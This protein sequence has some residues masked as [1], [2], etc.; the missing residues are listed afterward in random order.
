M[1]AGYA[2]R[3]KDYPNKG[4]CGLPELK[5]TPRQLKLK[6]E[7]L[8]KLVRDAAGIAE[9]SR[10]GDDSDSDDDSDDDDSDEEGSDGNEKKG[11]GKKKGKKGKQV[12]NNIIKPRGRIVVLTGAGISTSSGIPDFRGPRGIWTMEKN[13]KKTQKSN[14]QKNKKRRRGGGN[15]DDCDG[16]GD[17]VDKDEGGSS[18]NGGSSGSGSSGSKM[19]A[20]PKKKK[21]TTNGES[22]GDGN[23][24]TKDNGHGS[25]G[26]GAAAV[27]VAK[28][29]FAKAAPTYT[30]R[31]VTELVSRRRVVSYVVTQNVDGLHR[32]SGLSRNDHAVLH[33]CVFTEKCEKCGAEYFHD[34]DVGGMSFQPTGRRCTLPALGNDD[35]TGNGNGDGNGKKGCNG[36]LR[37]TLLDW[38]DGLPEDDYERSIAECENAD[39][40]LCL[41]TSLRIEPAGSLP[42]KAKKFVVVNLQQTPYDDKACL[43][44]RSRV[45]DVLRDLM[46]RLGFADDGAGGEPPAI[47]RVWRPPPSY[48][49]P[50]L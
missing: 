12:N 8:A 25:G 49:S 22:A 30:H 41:G 48:A 1:S 16:D 27:P 45:D 18:G 37:D 23:D 33:G 15:D 34:R 20:S 50:G 19:V 14:Q 6:L 32:R 17:D 5:E 43:V 3:L 7:A 47:E 13:Q 36:V 38:E 24:N 26:N 46:G 29:D 4:E 44:I 10:H 2:A 9:K 11:R 42:L 40:V 39:L 21:R 31:A 28:I 35:E